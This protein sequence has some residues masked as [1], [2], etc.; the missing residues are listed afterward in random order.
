M[1]ALHAELRKLSGIPSAWVAVVVGLVVPFAIAALNAGARNFG[2]AAGGSDPAGV[3]AGFQELAF[4]VIGVIILGVVAASSEYFAEGGDSA[5][6]R[7]ITASLTAVPSR[8]GF[9]AAKAGALALS[10][11]VLAAVSTAA[12]LAVSRAASGGPAAPLVLADAP[13][14][15]GVVAYWVLTALLA[16][17]LALLTRGGVV[18]LVVLILNTS[19]VSVTYLL[20][21]VTPLANYLPDMAGARMFIRTFRSSVEITPLVG[22]AV[23]AAWTLALLG[24]AAAVFLRRDA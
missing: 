8:V 9:L 14:A 18:P 23:M 17:G 2:R 3:D 7:Q 6:S 5:G 20:T 1:R 16:H 24:V 4:G 13:R 21:R 22:G 19:V 15:L 12:T 11:A 10:A